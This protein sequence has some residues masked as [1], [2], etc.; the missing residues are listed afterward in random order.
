MFALLWKHWLGCWQH[1]M[2]I[3]SVIYVQ[4][5][6]LKLFVVWGQGSDW[7]GPGHTRKFK[8]CHDG[9][10][11]SNQVF[12]IFSQAFL[13][14]LNLSFLVCEQSFS[15]LNFT[16]SI[17]KFFLNLTQLLSD[18][19]QFS[20]S[21]LPWGALLKKLG[22]QSGQIDN[23]VQFVCICKFWGL[24]W[25]SALLSRPVLLWLFIDNVTVR[26]VMIFPIQSIYFAFFCRRTL[27]NVW[28]FT[29]AALC[30]FAFLKS[31][32]NLV[33]FYAQSR[34]NL[35]QRVCMIFDFLQQTVQRVAVF[36][37]WLYFANKSIYV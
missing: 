33:F 25:I 20:L 6:L 7:F 14:L 21:G 22:L 23:L 12:F 32:P 18:F 34:L 29:L 13:P 10:S 30:A 2:I 27:V 24:I 19:C 35:L 17:H 37:L 15:Q 5:L 11:F 9:F 36:V 3:I 26:L 28:T 4:L 1:T 8:L 16:P 31:A